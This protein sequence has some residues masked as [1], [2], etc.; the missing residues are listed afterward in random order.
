MLGERVGAE[1]DASLVDMTPIGNG[2]KPPRGRQSGW[3]ATGRTRK[4]TGRDSERRPGRNITQTSPRITKEPT[5]RTHPS[6]VALGNLSTTRSGSE[7][8]RN[9][10]CANDVAHRNRRIEFTLIITTTAVLVTS[11][12]CAVYV[13]ARSIA[14]HEHKALGDCSSATPQ[15]KA[16]AEDATRPRRQ[17]V[18]LVG[19][20]GCM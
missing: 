10:P 7:R 12:G 11:N 19:V 13:T 3:R 17:A 9:Q 4:G 15:H 18:D 20:E 1:L 2:S 6:R 16:R 5:K 8:W 14:P